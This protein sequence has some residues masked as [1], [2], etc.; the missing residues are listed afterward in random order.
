MDE[1]TYNRI[2]TGT[3]NYIYVVGNDL[4]S[5]VAPAVDSVST[6]KWTFLQDN[7][8]ADS[9]PNQLTEQAEA[10]T[11]NKDQIASLQAKWV[12]GI[13]QQ[14]LPIE[15]VTRAD[16]P[17]PSEWAPSEE[18]DHIVLLDNNE[19]WF[20]QLSFQLKQH[21]SKWIVF[22]APADQ[23]ML[24][25]AKATGVPVMDLSNAFS[26]ELNW[27]SIMANRLQ[28]I[29]NQTWKPGAEDYNEQELKELKLK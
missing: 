4:L 12:D 15:W 24:Q 29:L 13:M 27:D 21:D 3:Y 10:V 20:Q 19:Q 16:H 23:T 2:K 14:G 25:K 26:I 17:I 9:L 28:E 22:Y 6:T 1:Q 18:A 11:V 5:N 8:T 7:L